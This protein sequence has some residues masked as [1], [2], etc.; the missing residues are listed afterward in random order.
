[1]L[2]AGS[3]TAAAAETRAFLDAEA[4]P[5]P[6]DEELP[7]TLFHLA[8]TV[9]QRRLPPRSHLE[10]DRRTARCTDARFSLL[11][12]RHAG[13]TLRIEPRLAEAAT[14]CD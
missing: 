1:M 7:A 12:R 8:Q 5:A 14:P 13:G 2:E 4:R 9:L 11:L 10:L 3:L 6:G